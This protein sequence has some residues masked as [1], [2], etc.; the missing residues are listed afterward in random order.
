MGIGTQSGSRADR[1]TSYDLAAFAPVTGAEEEWRFTPVDRLR[2]L[3]DTAPTSAGVAVTVEIPPGGAGASVAVERVSRSD[4]RLGKTMPPSDRAAAAAWAGFDEA[5]VVSVAEGAIVRGSI[6][7]GVRGKAGA[8]ASAAHILLV[9]APNSKATVLLDYTGSANLTETVEIHVGEGAALRVLSIYEW[10]LSTVH[11][12]SHRA[13][14]AKDA[15]LTHAAAALGGGVVR[16]TPDVEFAGPG[17]TAELLGLYLTDTGQHHEARLFVDHG[18]PHCTSRVTYKGAL[19]GAGAHTVWVGDVLIR[20]NAQGTDTYEQNRNLVLVRGA[21][22][23]SVPNLEIETGEIVGAG[24][25]SATGRFDDEQLFYLRSRGI[26][27][28]TARRL[29]VHGFFAALI[30]Q[31]GVPEVEERLIASVDRRLEA[32]LT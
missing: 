17:G 10:D 23:D 9:A 29:V 12:A 21:R 15:A 27:A 26:D 30:G 25:A 7:V 19:H 5:I 32:S 18:A 28:A 31:F 13:K 8:A 1:P 2:L 4:P 11:A 24:H 20:K 14:L 6:R 16:L 3:F 22:A